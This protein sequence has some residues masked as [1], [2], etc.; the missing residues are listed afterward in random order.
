MLPIPLESQRQGTLHFP[1]FRHSGTGGA[2]WKL[3]TSYPNLTCVAPL[4]FILVL[5]I[6][7]APKP[8][9]APLHHSV[10]RAVFLGLENDFVQ[11]V[12]GFPI[13]KASMRS[14]RCVGTQEEVLTA[15][16]G[17]DQISRA[18]SMEKAQ[19]AHVCTCQGLSSACGLGPGLQTWPMFSPRPRTCKVS[20]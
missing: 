7:T 9:L 19:T 13:A 8:V 5:E 1:L 12:Q 6:L 11:L 14:G 10:S 15:P 2:G 17:G 3:W 18:G 16:S 20:K 4:V